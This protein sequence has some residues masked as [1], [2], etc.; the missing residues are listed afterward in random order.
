MSPVQAPLVPSK[1]VGRTLLKTP[2]SVGYKGIEEPLSVAKYHEL[3]ESGVL[4]TEDR[5][6][7]LNG[8]LVP[9][10]SQN[11]PHRIAMTRTNRCLR[12]ATD[13]Q[14]AHVLNQTPLTLDTSEPEPDICLIRGSEEAFEKL[15]RHPSPKDLLLLAEVADTSLRFDRGEKLGTYATSGIANYWIIN[16][17]DRRIECY[18]DPDATTATYRTMRNYSTGEVIEWQTPELG[19]LRLNVADLLPE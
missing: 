14:R 16:L 11:P 3:I 6:E 2:L 15:G 1:T 10:M 19:A 12:D 7:L 13:P 18:S 17:N 5:I 4:T 8:R 9:K